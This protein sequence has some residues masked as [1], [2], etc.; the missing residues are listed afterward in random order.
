MSQSYSFNEPNESKLYRC[1]L[2]D[3]TLPHEELNKAY[4]NKSTLFFDRAM[5]QFSLNNSNSGTYNFKNVVVFSDSSGLGIFVPGPFN[6][7]NLS[8]SELQTPN[9]IDIGSYTPAVTPLKIIKRATFSIYSIYSISSATASSDNITQIV[10]STG[11]K[12]EI[13]VKLT[14]SDIPIYYA[15]LGVLF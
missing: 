3:R 5:D 4:Y 13:S 15:K 14:K 10:I 12:N 1:D 7:N 9:Q 8:D 6:L 11:L 2:C